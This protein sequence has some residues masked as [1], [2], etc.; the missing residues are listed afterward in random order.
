MCKTNLKL[1]AI[2][3]AV[4]VLFLSAETLEEDTF[5]GF[6]RPVCIRLA[7][8]LPPGSLV[9]VGPIKVSITE[10]NILFSELG[11]SPEKTV[12]FANDA[13]STYIMAY[14]TN[15][16]QNNTHL[17]LMNL[18]MAVLPA[19]DR[20]KIQTHD[21]VNEETGLKIMNALNVDNLIVGEFINVNGKWIFR[22]G[23]GNNSIDSEQ[24]DHEAML[25]LLRRAKDWY[26]GVE[27]NSGTTPPES[28]QQERSTQT[29][30]ETLWPGAAITL[31]FRPENLRPASFTIALNADTFISVYAPLRNTANSSTQPSFIVFN[32]DG[33][34]KLND[35]DFRDTINGVLSNQERGEFYVYSDDGKVIAYSLSTFDE[36]YRI[37]N[38]RPVNTISLTRNNCLVTNPGTAGSKVFSLATKAEVRG[39][40]GALI[41]SAAVNTGSLSLTVVEGIVIMSDNGKEHLRLAYYRDGS[42][43]II[44]NE[45]R[46]YNGTDLIEHH[47][48][49]IERNR[50]IRPFRQSDRNMRA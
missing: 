42:F 17:S 12:E 44:K 13:L 35:S 5:S 19:L 3:L 1:L 24:F 43:G 28:T 37:N 48:D 27:K 34:V 22:I 11:L 49:V 18:P 39:A 9:A 41:A 45:Q 32:K 4:M 31:A 36:L 15:F 40:A 46:Q 33:V 29:H 6:I 30:Q 47:L 2:V 7:N 26:E 16:L 23:V 20:L 8:L 38:V 10:D 50:P 14:I 21:D 25:R